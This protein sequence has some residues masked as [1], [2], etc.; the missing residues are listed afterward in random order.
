MLSLGLAR[1]GVVGDARLARLASGGDEAA[2]GAIFRRYHQ[3]LYRYCRAI[4]GDGE[5]AADALQNTMVKAMRSLPGERRAIELKP[6]LFRVAHNESVS[7]L[8]QRRPAGA[9]E[10]ATSGAVEGPEMGLAAR[11]DLR[12]LMLDLSELPDRQRATMILR[13]LNGLSHA[14]IASVFGTST[15]AAKQAAYDGRRALQDFAKGRAMDCEAVMRAISDRDGKLLGARGL[16]GHLRSCEECASFKR[17][18]DQR[19]S[20]LAAMAPALPATAA[21]G[22]MRKLFGGG[23]SAGGGSVG[24]AAAG[25][26]LVVG[27]GALKGASAALAAVTVAASVAAGGAQLSSDERAPGGAHSAG[28][29]SGAA[30]IRGRDGRQQSKSGTA[31]PGRG[32]SALGARSLGRN[33][34]PGR[35]EVARGSRSLDHDAVPGGFGPQTD[36]RPGGEGSPGLPDQARAGRPGAQGLAPGP[37]RIRRP[38]QAG[39]HREAVGRPSPQAGP[40]AA[41]PER[42]SRPP[43]G[44]PTAPKS[45]AQADLPVSREPPGEPPSRAPGSPRAPEGVARPGR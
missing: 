33:G 12:E 24:L 20:Q 10:E 42:P 11:E 35:V 17:A 25:G 7:L 19:S 37:V 4:T 14:E 13:E 31:L 2:F 18:L 28:E 30:A 41:R 16:R 43:A 1:L 44:A 21:V 22:L 34:A 45:P 32:E 39:G 27:G 29:S 36:G 6:W 40:P 15:V 8:R 26:K 9:L 5:D 3:P 38:E 23:G